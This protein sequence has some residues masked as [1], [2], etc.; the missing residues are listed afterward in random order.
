MWNS[1]STPSCSPRDC[2]RRA[3]STPATAASYD[4]GSP[5][6]LRPDLTD[7]SDRPSRE[8]GSC[9]PF[10]SDEATVQPVWQRLADRA[11]QLGRP[12]PVRET[13]TDAG[14]QLAAKGRRIKPIF[15][16]ADLAIFALPRGASEVGLMSRA[17]S[18]TDARPWLDDRRRLGVRVARIVLA[19]RTRCGRSRWII[20]TS[21][22]AGGRLSV[23]GRPWADGPTA[24]PYCR[25]RRC[26]GTPCWRST[27]LAR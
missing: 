9:A 1:T 14:L 8:A 12:V 13:T 24:R 11:A 16:S 6:V 7:N 3:T 25:C 27:W 20:R 2:R 5:L 19:A 15:A 26:V 22:A 23:T 18:P 10:V 17:A 4:F 21:A